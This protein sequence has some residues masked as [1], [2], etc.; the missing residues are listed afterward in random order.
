MEILIKQNKT[1]KEGF[2][3]NQFQNKYIGDD[4]AVVGKWV[5]S[6]DSFFEN[7]HFKRQWLTLKQIASKAMLVNISDAIVM[8]S[9]PKYA[10][11]SVAIPKDFT[12]KQL[13]KL[14][15]GFIKVAKEYNIQIIGG[16]TISNDKLDITVTIISKLN[17]KPTTRANLKFGDIVAYTGQLGKS[18]K[19][20]K[21]LFN[22]QKISKDSV[23]IKPKLKDKFFYEIAPFINCALDISDGLSKELERLSAINQVDFKFIK[24]IKNSILCSG[25]EY[26]ILFGYSP[27]NSKKIAKIA[28]KYQVKLTNIAYVKQG[29]YQSKCKG[30][31]F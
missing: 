18:Q 16:D 8:N 23:F 29:K 2:F 9:T 13:K 31:H 6:M 24:H 28:K 3:I 27:K 26:E 14:A 19:D 10:L 11:L 20:L 22:N 5:Y 21:R 1:D 15:K 25:E 12:H 17:G 30:H 4:G 7:V